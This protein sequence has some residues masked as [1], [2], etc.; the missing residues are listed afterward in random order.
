MISHLLRFIANVDEELTGESRNWSEGE[1]RLPCF[2]VDS[3]T[4]QMRL[5]LLGAF[6]LTLVLKY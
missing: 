2:N 6:T 1:Y 5:I 4:T 3:Y